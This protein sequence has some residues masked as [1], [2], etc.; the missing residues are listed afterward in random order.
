MKCYKTIDIYTLGIDSSSTYT[1]GALFNKEIEVI[2]RLLEE[3]MCN[4]DN[5]V[6]NKNKVTISSMCTDFAES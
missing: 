6:K 3:D 5:F 4:I 1:K 2:M